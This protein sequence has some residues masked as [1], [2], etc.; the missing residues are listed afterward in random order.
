MTY[1]CVEL[2]EVSKRVHIT[3]Q[4]LPWSYESKILNLSEKFKS[5]VPKKVNLKAQVCTGKLTGHDWKEGGMS[6]AQG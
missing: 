5:N 1:V 6:E 2:R 4:R 3:C